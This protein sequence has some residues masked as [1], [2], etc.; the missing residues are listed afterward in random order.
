MNQTNIKKLSLTILATLACGAVMAGELRQAPGRDTA[1]TKMPP[2]VNINGFGGNIET[3]ACTGCNFDEVFGGYYEAGPSNCELLGSQQWIAVPFVSKR[4][5]TTRSV[6]AGIENDPACVGSSTQVT[7]GIYNDDCT[8]GV[9][10][11]IAVG[12]ANVSNGPCVLAVAR[13]RAALVLGTRYWVA[14]T[15]SSTQAGLSAVWYPSNQAEIG[16]NLGS[17]W[18]FFNGLVPSFSVD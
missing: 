12:K 4:T 8:T 1:P 16:Y 2:A 13:V 5:G 10:T 15:T 11:Q 3:N 14:A 7:L 18:A 6:S 17:G 9:G